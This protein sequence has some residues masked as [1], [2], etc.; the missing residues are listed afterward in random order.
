MTPEITMTLAVM[1]MRKKIIFPMAFKIFLAQA[2]KY[3]LPT[4]TK[5]LQLPVMM[6]NCQIWKMM[7]LQN[8]TISCRYLSSQTLRKR[9]R[10]M[11]CAT[12]S[13]ESMIS[14]L[15]QLKRLKMSEFVMKM[16]K[17]RSQISLMMMILILMIQTKLFGLKFSLT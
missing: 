5:Q 3:S 12:L 7:S 1:M 4:K 11:T 13:T 8:L 10:K 9:K 14:F 15:K 6:T 17:K 16:R 2:R